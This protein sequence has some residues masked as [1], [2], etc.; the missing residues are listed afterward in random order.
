MKP[1]YK[2]PY[3]VAFFIGA[4]MLT[5]IRPFLRKVP[6]PPPVIGLAPVFTLK[7]E[8]G[9]AFGSAN[10]KGTTYV[11]NFLFTSCTTACPLLVQSLQEL[12]KR[13]EQ[14]KIP[15][16]II[17]FS[18]DPTTDTPEVLHTYAAAAKADPQRWVFLTGEVPAVAATL[19]GFNFALEPKVWTKQ[20]FFEI[21]HTQKLV[22]V[23]GNGAVRGYYG[24]DKLGVDEV[25]HR[26]QH[27]LRSFGVNN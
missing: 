9:E 5:F 23:D 1:F 11:A 19:K 22:I 17:S 3:L 21:S 15:I 8:K 20:S 16:K 7:N 2:N 6:K 24:S 26:S 13:Y 27:V 4:A 14:E 12:Q 25:F 10:L 18:V